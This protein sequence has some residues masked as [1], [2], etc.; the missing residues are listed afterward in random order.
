VILGHH[1]WYDGSSGYPEKYDTSTSKV[2]S[3]ID[4][5][6]I[7]DSLDAGT[8]FYGRNYAKKKTFQDVLE[9]L[10]EGAGTHYN[11]D[12]VALISDDS[13]LYNEINDLLSVNRENYYFDLVKIHLQSQK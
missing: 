7:C 12:F 3:I 10:K 9:E 6:S 13:E 4:I 5:I 11:P 1:K 2:K 8:D